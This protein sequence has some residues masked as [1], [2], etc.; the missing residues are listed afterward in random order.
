MSG[1]VLNVGRWGPLG[2]PAGGRKPHAGQQHVGGNPSSRKGLSNVGSSTEVNDNKGENK[3]SGFVRRKMGKVLLYLQTCSARLGFDGSSGSTPSTSRRSAWSLLAVVVLFL[4]LFAVASALWVRSVKAGPT[5]RFWYEENQLGSREVARSWMD[6]MSEE[7]LSA[8]V[9]LDRSLGNHEPP[10]DGGLG[11]AFAPS[12][13]QPLDTASPFPAA[14]I[15][16]IVTMELGLDRSLQRKRTGDLNKEESPTDETTVNFQ[17]SLPLLLLRVLLRRL[18]SIGNV[19]LLVL[20]PNPSFGSAIPKPLDG[21]EEQK[22]SEGFSPKQTERTNERSA[23]GDSVRQRLDR[24]KDGIHSHTDLK[25]RFTFVYVPTIPAST[26]ALLNN[27]TRMV[28]SVSGSYF[29]YLRH[30]TLPYG[31]DLGQWLKSLHSGVE[32]NNVGVVGCPVLTQKSIS[33]RR[34]VAKSLPT[35][36]ADLVAQLKRGPKSSVNE[37]ASVGLEIVDDALGDVLLAPRLAGFSQRDY[38]LAAGSSCGRSH[39]QPCV[40][41]EAVDGLTGD[42]LIIR[43]DVWTSMGGFHELDSE[44]RASSTFLSKQSRTLVNFVFSIAL[45]KAAFSRL[46]AYLEWIEPTWKA[47]QNL[48]VEHSMRWDLLKSKKGNALAELEALEGWLREGKP[49]LGSQGTSPNSLPLTEPCR[50]P[51]VSWQLSHLPPIAAVADPETTF[52]EANALRYYAAFMTMTTN[53]QGGSEENLGPAAARK[54]KGNSKKKAVEMKANKRGGDG[55]QW[56]PLGRSEDEVQRALLLKVDQES[57]FDDAKRGIEQALASATL[58]DHRSS[59]LREELEA[60]F[61]AAIADQLEGERAEEVEKRIARNAKL[62]DRERQRRRLKADQ[63]VIRRSL[64]QP[65]AVDRN[66]LRYALNESMNEAAAAKERAIELALEEGHRQTLRLAKAQQTCVDAFKRLV[67]AECGHMDTPFWELSLRA[68]FM[69]NYSTVVALGAQVVSTSPP[70]THSSRYSHINTLHHSSS[71]QQWEIPGRHR[72]SSR[73]LT[74]NRFTITWTGYCCQCCGFTNEIA[75]LLDPLTTHTRV[76]TA[77]PLWCHCRGLPQSVKENI[78]RM[79]VIRGGLDELVESQSTDVAA[80]GNIK[81]RGVTV[82]ATPPTK[83]EGK[84]PA[85]GNSTK[86]ARRVVALSDRTNAWVYHADP[87]TVRD[88]FLVWSEEKIDYKI[89]RSMYEFTRL[90]TEWVPLLVEQYDEIWVP[91]TFVE[92]TYIASGVPAK[93]IFRVPEPV[94]TKLYDPNSVEPLTLPAAVGRPKWRSLGTHADAYQ[95]RSEFYATS[96]SG[97]K[98]LNS[99]FPQERLREQMN[100]FKFLSIFKWEPRKGPGA[101]LKAFFQAFKASDPVSLYLHTYLWSQDPSLV[102]DPR[103]PKAVIRQFIEPIALSLLNTTDWPTKAQ[104]IAR[105]EADLKARADST[106]HPAEVADGNAETNRRGG[107]KSNDFYALSTL[108]LEHLPNVEVITEPTSEKEVVELYRGCDAFV[109]LSYGEG[110]GLPVMQ[111]LSMGLPTIATAWSGLK[112]FVLEEHSFPVPIEREE[113]LPPWPVSP[114]RFGSA[115]T[116]PG[117][118][119]GIPNHEKAVEAMRFVFHQRSTASMLQKKRKARQFAVE[120]Y[121]SAIIAKRVAARLAAIEAEVLQ[122]RKKDAECL[123]DCLLK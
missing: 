74:S 35:T 26:S 82:K 63:A 94:D 67:A 89:S 61:H 39:R 56:I 120:Q 99:A 105:L 10:V 121:D 24:L 68:Q 81:N 80:M 92:E 38:R 76:R 106:T 114:Y 84:K 59:Q 123:E 2:F 37:I 96:V 16:V 27:V 64:H 42:G 21:E 55:Q 43:A 122:K 25:S 93:K 51:S 73:R 87:L 15:D 90:P 75:Q 30:D 11:S 91:S 45:Y 49:I 60:G 54:Q 71:L 46:V 102:P 100:H 7:E 95:R 97:K 86:V 22:G 88:G 50:N 57:A 116:T 34:Q 40:G 52:S 9:D 41:L 70:S 13:S 4:G 36:P 44:S 28:H 53:Q 107:K 6:D 58:I 12:G 83:P 77:L 3:Q 31:E 33:S 108:L 20:D 72:L 18:T 110:W 109:L 8:L 85:G 78:A 119:W 48:H 32:A 5:A 115:A 112:D 29:L 23:R 69:K 65:S 111:A 104:D 101:L 103:S 19:A 113:E 98:P 79:Q 47:F 17:G 66:R 117:M 62:D 118:K 1:S 14:S